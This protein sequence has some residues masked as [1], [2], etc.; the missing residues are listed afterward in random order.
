MRS[1]KLRPPGAPQPRAPPEVRER[2]LAATSGR[3]S[4]PLYLGRL[5]IEDDVYNGGVNAGQLGGIDGFDFAF[6]AR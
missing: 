2:P 3:W 6:A 4:L 1:W 5:P